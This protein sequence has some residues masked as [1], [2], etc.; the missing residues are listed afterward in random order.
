MSYYGL[1][2]FIYIIQVIYISIGLMGIEHSVRVYLLKYNGKPK[3][4]E[5]FMGYLRGLS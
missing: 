2:I 5:N 4:I 1:K 3:G